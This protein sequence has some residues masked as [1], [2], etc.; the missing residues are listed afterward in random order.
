MLAFINRCLRKIL[1]IKWSETVTKK[2]LR[3]R[4]GQKPLDRQVRRENGP[5]LATHFVNHQE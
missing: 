4:T 5:G 1:W 3:E 2:E